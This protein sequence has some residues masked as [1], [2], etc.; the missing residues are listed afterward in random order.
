MMNDLLA[1]LLITSNLTV[2]EVMM[3]MDRADK[4]VLFVVDENKCLLGSVTDGDIRR[5]ILKEG[6]LKECI[7][8]VCNKH[9]RS[10]CGRTDIEGVSDFMSQN[11]LKVLPIVNAD[12]VV[13]DILLWDNIS[14]DKVCKKVVKLNVPVLI[15]AG[16][17]GTRLDPFTKILPKPLIPVG[18][19]PMVEH[20]MDRF[21]LFGCR[22]YYLTVN[23]KGKMVQ[24]Y[25]DNMENG[26]N[27][28]YV[29]EE[30]F[31]GT[32]GSLRLA[33]PL[34]DAP[35]IFVSN[36]DVL[37]KAD[38]EDIY[39][40]HIQNDNDITVIGS[41]QHVS[42]PFGVLEVKNGGHLEGI[43]EKPEYDFL[44]NTGMYLIKRQ[45]TELIEPNVPSDFTHLL[46]RTKEQGG[47]VGVYPISQKSWID[48]GQWQEY[49]GAL[50]KMGLDD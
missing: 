49:H 45:V 19:K 14:T 4:K 50:K 26:Y 44:A 25:F 33:V 46:E 41:M 24:S 7:D 10:V 16:G 20:I 6:S 27:I 32:A 12:N 17:K 8:K 15:M 29:W 42:V 9:V 30:T 34:I 38:Y 43:V 48:I 23:Y 11:M 1:Q 3:C 39:N 2:K 28:N 37:I 36:C 31:L 40:S 13:I 18:D 35:H 5:W 21:A 47:K 22:D